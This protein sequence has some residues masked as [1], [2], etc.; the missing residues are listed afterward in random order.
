MKTS[1]LTDTQWERLRPLLPPQKPRTGRPPKNH[2]AVLN[3]ILWI[4]RT[5][6]PWR[7][8]PERYGSWKT[9]SSRF[10]RWQK[11]G[12]WDRI[13][14][15]LQRRADAEGRLDWSLHFVDSTVVRAHQH[16]AGAKGGTQPPTPSAGVAAG[17]A[18]RS[19]F[20]ASAAASRWGSS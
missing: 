14:S 6:S 5:G 18:R 9:I 17:T 13:L 11:A 4:L 19:I 3:G 15:T 20:A 12:V 1:D 2:R 10:Y 8:L 16:A 7:A